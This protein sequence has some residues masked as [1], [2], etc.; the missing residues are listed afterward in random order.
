[1][2]KQVNIQ[3][4]LTY[5][6]LIGLVYCILLYFRWDNASN[7]ILYGLLS[8]VNYLIVLGIMFFAAFQRRKVNGGFIDLKNLFQT[9]FVSV[10]IF[11]LIFA[12]YNYVHLKFID[13]NVLDRMKAGILQ[14]LDQAGAQVT[15][16]QREDSLKGIKEMEKALEFIQIVKSYLISIA[17]SGFFAFII[18]LIMRKNHPDQG[19][20]QKI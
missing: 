11:E 6:V 18:A 7:L 9:L 17:I 8:F 2:N 1:M 20:P 16:Q 14:M 5:G 13:P 12:A 19:M 15:E 3:T 4:G 10:L